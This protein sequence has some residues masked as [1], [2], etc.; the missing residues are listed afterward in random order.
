MVNIKLMQK[1]VLGNSLIS[2]FKE[3]KY[4]FKQIQAFIQANSLF[5]LIHVLLPFFITFQLE[6]CPI[7]DKQSLVSLFAI[8]IHL[9]SST[10]LMKIREAYFIEN[11]IMFGIRLTN[12]SIFATYDFILRQPILLKIK[13]YVEKDTPG[14]FN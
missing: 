1:G 14:W 4:K 8:H 9:L 13:P 7:S 12:S 2:S 5:Y 10:T 11:K 3:V 6:F